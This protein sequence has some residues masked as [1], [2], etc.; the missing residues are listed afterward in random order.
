[1]MMNGI[2]VTMERTR[3]T[4]CL[5]VPSETQYIR[6]VAAELVDFVHRST[7][8]EDDHLTLVLS[9]AL[10]NSII[11][12]NKKNPR[13]KVSAKVTIQPD[14]LVFKIADEGKGFDYRNLPDP[15]IK[16]NLLKESGRGN[17]L[18]HFFM[19]EVRFNKSGNQITMVKYIN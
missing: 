3:Q 19:D 6:K 9:E 2:F 1:M 14:R 17:F 10:A 13:K 12:G 11:H 7:N 5:R 16:E 18:I 8:I 4:K 15:R